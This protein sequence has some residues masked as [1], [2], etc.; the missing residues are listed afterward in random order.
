[1]HGVQRRGNGRKLQDGIGSTGMAFSAIESFTQ[2]ALSPAAPSARCFGYSKGPADLSA[3]PKGTNETR[4]H[5]IQ[6]QRPLDVHG[7]HAGSTCI[8]YLLW[9][10][11][12]GNHLP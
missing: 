11:S 3:A 6:A 1:M 2:S 7:T 4:I 9:L 12:I 5:E 10:S 8:D